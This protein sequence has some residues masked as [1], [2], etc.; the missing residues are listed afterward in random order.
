L[1]KA[2]QDNAGPLNIVTVI[3]SIDKGGVINTAH[4]DFLVAPFNRDFLVDP[5]GGQSLNLLNR[6]QLRLGRPNEKRTIT[7]LVGNWLLDFFQIYR[8]SVVPKNRLHF[9]LFGLY[10]T[11]RNFAGT[12]LGSVQNHEMNLHK[13]VSTLI[14][15]TSERYVP[16]PGKND[17]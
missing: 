13:W 2:G 10:C 8:K 7:I 11:S 4:F 14:C 5:N 16:E 15:G 9:T 1:V 6:F 12:S 3:L 17:I